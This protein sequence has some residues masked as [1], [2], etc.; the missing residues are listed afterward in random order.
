MVFDDRERKK[1]NRVIESLSLSTLTELKTHKKTKQ[2]TGTGRRL[3]ETNLR[4][5]T[6]SLSL[7]FAREREQ[8]RMDMY[9]CKK[10]GFKDQPRK[11]LVFYL[12]TYTYDQRGEKAE[13]RRE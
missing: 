3:Q 4:F 2:V 11:R 13:R 10:W 12:F 5:V 1:S 6:A 9:D 8:N 7:L